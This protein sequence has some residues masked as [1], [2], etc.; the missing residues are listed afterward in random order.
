MLPKR[1]TKSSVILYISNGT[2]SVY[3]RI[4]DTQGRPQTLNIQFTTYLN[5]AEITGYLN[6]VLKYNW[7]SSAVNTL[8]QQTTPIKEA[9]KLSQYKA[10]VTRKVFKKKIHCHL[11]LLQDNKMDIIAKGNDQ[12]LPASQK[13]KTKQAHSEYTI[14]PG[15]NTLYP[16][17]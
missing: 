14:V 3:L 1:I 16:L 11:L 15:P 4:Q 5:K 9:I 8:D 12:I 6:P 2:D 7:T 13:Q 10:Y 17:L